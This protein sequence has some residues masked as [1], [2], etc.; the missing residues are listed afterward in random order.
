MD[1][2]AKKEYEDLAATDKQRYVDEMK[3]YKEMVQPDKGEA[4][5][6]DKLTVW[7]RFYKY[8]SCYCL[9]R[10]LSVSTVYFWNKLPIACG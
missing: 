2:E 7:C 4:E 6:R 9:A 1:A 5:R 8:R 10:V 3:A